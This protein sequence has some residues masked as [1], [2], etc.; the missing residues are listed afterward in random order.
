M[1]ADDLTCR[2]GLWQEASCPQSHLVD[3]YRQS[4]MRLTRNYPSHPLVVVCLLANTHKY[5]KTQLHTKIQIY[6]QSCGKP[7]TIQ[8]IPLYSC[9]YSKTHINEVVTASSLACTMHNTLATGIWFDFHITPSTN[10]LAYVPLRCIIRHDKACWAIL[11][12]SF[13]AITVSA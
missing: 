2:G 4:V 11:K 7:E 9:A 1:W 12:G 13:S 5:T 8:L 6:T 10:E 3:R